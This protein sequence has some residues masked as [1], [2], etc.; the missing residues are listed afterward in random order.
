MGL[1]ITAIFLLLGLMVLSI[2]LFRTDAHLKKG[3][4]FL[5]IWG[6]ALI[7]IGLWFGLVQI[8]NHLGYP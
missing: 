3:G 7:F 5:A 4:I 8:L 6:V 2:A 1:L